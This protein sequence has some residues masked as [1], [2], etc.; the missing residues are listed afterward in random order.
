MHDI[1]FVVPSTLSNSI[2]TKY[3][4]TKIISE[5][6]VV[7]IVIHSVEVVTVYIVRK[8]RPDVYSL[9]LMREASTHS[10]SIMDTVICTASRANKCVLV[11]VR[12]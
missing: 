3:K 2:N 1:E 9:I 4:F 8:A 7:L 6:N 5:F 10:H 12:V 11:S